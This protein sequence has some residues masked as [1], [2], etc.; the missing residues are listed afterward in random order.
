VVK[1]A[2]E[3]CGKNVVTQKQPESD[4]VVKPCSEHDKAAAPET[5]AECEKV[6]KS[7]SEDDKNAAA[8]THAECEKVVK[9]CSKAQVVKNQ[10]VKSEQTQKQTEHMHDVVKTDG[11]RDDDAR[12]PHSESAAHRPEQTQ[13]QATDNSGPEEAVTTQKQKEDSSHRDE[14]TE[15]QEQTT[16]NS[17]QDENIETQK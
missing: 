10:V 12:T 17:G 5:H 15:T 11:N 13:N 6:V 9:S 7:R 3:G 2:E 1:S 4:Q 14:T 8:E 16:Q